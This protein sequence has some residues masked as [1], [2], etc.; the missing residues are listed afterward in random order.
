MKCTKCGADIREGCKF[1]VRCGAKIEKE[2]IE[3]KPENA[4]EKRESVTVVT[5]KMEIENTVD[6]RIEPIENTVDQRTEPIE[7]TMD[8]R[9]ERIEKIMSLRTEQVKKETNMV[10]VALNVVATVYLAAVVYS[11]LW[12]ID[13]NIQDLLN[14]LI[15][16]IVVIA[17]LY[18]LA[19]IV[20][21]LTD[22]KNRM[23]R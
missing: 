22:I 5:Q 7:K 19:Q 18:G 4:E 21:L 1:C 12:M 20:Q 10:A 9:A 23:N 11:G 14:Y 3:K 13:G 2:L 6:Q 8:Q 16:N 17:A 15:W